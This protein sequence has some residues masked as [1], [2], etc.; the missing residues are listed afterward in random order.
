M[1][2][3]WKSRVGR[4]VGR[5]DSFCP[6]DTCVSFLSYSAQQLLGMS[7]P[8]KEPSLVCPVESCFVLCSREL[9]PA[10]YLPKTAAFRLSLRP[11]WPLQT[12]F[13][14]GHIKCALGFNT[15]RGSKKKG[16]GMVRNFLHVTELTP[17][18]S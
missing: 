18:S 14:L 12:A 2:P 10:S 17:K 7:V 3:L 6:I 4:K 5:R 11:P 8:L 16:R 15:E 9:K 1:P 13:H